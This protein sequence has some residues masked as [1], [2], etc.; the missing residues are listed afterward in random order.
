M[1][2]N[3]NTWKSTSN[4]NSTRNSCNYNGDSCTNSTSKRNSR[5]LS[6]SKGMKVV[7]VLLAALVLVLVRTTK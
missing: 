7:I 6:T 5:K 3:N 2:K 1:K 4:S